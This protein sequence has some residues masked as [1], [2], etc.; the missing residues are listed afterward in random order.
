MKYTIWTIFS[1]FVGIIC[2]LAIYKVA[3][4]EKVQTIVEPIISETQ[5]Q[6]NTT[7][8]NIVAK[9]TSF[10]FMK[11]VN[12]TPKV[13]AG[14]YV[15]GDLDTGEII[16]KKNENQK[17]PIASVSK[18][19]TTL[20]A[21]MLPDPTGVAIVSKNALNTY[22][23]NGNLQLGE[24]I[25][26]SDIFYPLLMESSNDAA[27]VIAEHFGRENFLQK[28][29]QEAQKLSLLNTSFEDP[30]GL[31]PNNKSTAHDLFSLAGYIKIN[32]PEIFNITLNRSYSNKKHYWF[33][34]NQ[35]INNTGYIGGK[36]GYTDEA[37]Q[38]VVSTFSLPLAQTGNR[39][40]GVVLLHTPD[41]KKDVENI[42]KY[43][44]KNIY[45][46]GEFDAKSDWVKTKEG[47][48]D[49]AEPDYINLAFLGDI[50]VDRG[51]KSSVRK[52]FNGDYSSLFKNMGELNKNDIVFAN[53][54]GPASD[55][56]IDKKNLYSFNMDP[57]AIPAFKGGGIDIV[58]VANN[59]VGDW[60]RDAY[61][62]TLANL[63]ENEILYTGGGN[64]KMEANEP[65]IIEKNG[66]KIGY[67]A[68][69]DKGPSWMV[70]TET[71]PGLL[72][73]SDPEFDKIVQ[74]ASKKVD[75]LVVSFHFG[76]EYQLAHNERQAFLAHKAVDDGAKFVIGAHPHVIEDFE[77]YKESLIAY[78][79]GNF[80]FDQKFSD[81]TMQGMLLE[82]KL[83]KN[84][85]IETT[86]NIVKLNS[87]FQPDKIVKGKTE[88]VKF[89]IAKIQ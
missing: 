78:S 82:V 20:T 80:I 48:P 28:M 27:E 58:S 64:N 24:K 57:S 56:G 4:Y 9:P 52:N 30:S 83:H 6:Q 73:A 81:N 7:D 18:L 26:M 35:F 85:Q 40:I 37:L 16:L 38:T 66:M 55:K 51:V 25:K 39:N 60:G 50:M 12:A 29:N 43:I 76:E 88:K 46:G 33:S 71:Q 69:S 3:G 15:V 70:A 36:S 87:V 10:Y 74:N 67:L 62:D 59:H 42:I 17:L 32:K 63:K 53:L 5:T 75:Y 79:L 65:T 77:V 13:S 23:K 34:T 22:G 72:L 84:G 2:A 21:S 1:I 11:D 14:A 86:K 41:R 19:M 8:Q 49:I 47:I 89:Q 45:Y 31:S 61:I 54:E 68:F 44:R